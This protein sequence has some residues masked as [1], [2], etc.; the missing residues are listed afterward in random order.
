VGSFGL[1]PAAVK[2]GLS[3]A[4][5]FLMTIAMAAMG[6]HTPFAMIRKAGMRV[7]YAGLAAFAGMALIS[8]SLI[9]ALRIG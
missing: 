4:S 5:V 7:V 1:L 9:H 6:L 8:F 2:A 3:K